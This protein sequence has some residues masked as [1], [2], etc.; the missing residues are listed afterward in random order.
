MPNVKYEIIMILNTK[1]GEEGIQALS[2]RF[3]KMME[4][5]GTIEGIEEWGKRRLA[6]PIEDEVEGYYVLTH[7]TC[8]PDF[9]KELDRV[10][11]ITDGILR[12][13]IVR[14][15]DEKE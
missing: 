11:G 3:K 7:L 5:N 15:D 6:Y 10:F 8:S 2:A 4:D 14:V 1:L 12:S 13:L 9:P